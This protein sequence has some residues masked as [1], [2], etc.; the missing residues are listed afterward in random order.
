[1]LHTPLGRYS[2]ERTEGSTSGATLDISR[3]FA[4]VACIAFGNRGASIRDRNIELERSVM[5]I[6]G[7]GSVAI[8][9]YQIGLRVIM[10]VLLP[11]WA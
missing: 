1:V 4:L 2:F 10:F 11:A 9:G 8:A 6:A 3:K 7:F 5:I